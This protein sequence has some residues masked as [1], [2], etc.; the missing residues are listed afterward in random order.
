MQKMMQ[1]HPA[2]FTVATLQPLSNQLTIGS[3]VCIA[4]SIFMTASALFPMNQ[5]FFVCGALLA[6]AIWWA[7]DRFRICTLGAD[8]SDL[9]FYDAVIWTISAICFFFAIDPAIGWYFSTAI[10]ILKLIRIY[11]W[12]G[13]E[14]GDGGWGVFGPMTYFYEKRQRHSGGNVLQGKRLLLLG[15]ALLAAAIGSVLFKQLPDLWRVGIM[16][17]LSLGFELLNGPT[18]LRTVSEFVQQLRASTEREADLVAENAKLKQ[19]NQ[20]IADL[21]DL[22][23]A[24]LA[25]FASAVRKMTPAARQHVL[26]YAEIIGESYSPGPVKKS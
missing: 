5:W 13:S 23:P 22:S 15:L 25:T 4:E 18:Q 1:A 3:T 6:M 26:E 24:E 21:H 7:L 2:T 14:F 19:I 10:S 9:N 11:A 17:A 20:T 12:Q 8:I 16:W